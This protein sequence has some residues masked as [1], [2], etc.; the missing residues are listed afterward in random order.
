[1]NVSTKR[2]RGCKALEKER[3]WQWQQYIMW[4]EYTRM[5]R[6]LKIDV[7]PNELWWMN[8]QLFIGSHR[9]F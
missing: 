1:M 7:E 5:S 2:K 3:E 8:G 4:K 9:V 6:R